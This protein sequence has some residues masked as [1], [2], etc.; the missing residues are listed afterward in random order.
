MAIGNLA[1]VYANN[2][3]EKTAR[4]CLR[5]CKDILRETAG[6]DDADYIHFETVESKLNEYM[7]Q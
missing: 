4:E 1:R 5:Q 2:G 6:E 3:D 7:D